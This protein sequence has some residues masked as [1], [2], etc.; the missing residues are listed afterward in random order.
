MHQSLAL[1][2]SGDERTSAAVVDFIVIGAMRA[3]TTMLNDLL[4]QHPE[5]AMARMKETDFFIDTKNYRLGTDWYGSQFAPGARLRGEVSPNYSK[6]RD[7]PDVPRRIHGHCPAVRLVYML[8]DPVE[9]ALS[10]Y[11]HGWSMGR[12]TLLPDQL[13]GG[14]QYEGMVDASRY[15]RQLAQYHRH[16][17]AEQ[18]LILDFESFRADP[19][20][21]Y[22]ALLRHIGAAP[23]PVPSARRQNESSELARVP[24]PLLK[25]A[26]GPLRPVLTRV[27][28]PAVRGQLRRLM[29]R[30]PARTPP[31]FT[32]KLRD[33]LCD[34]LTED[35]ATLRAMTG[36]AFPDWSV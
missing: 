15:A 28:N 27:F 25:L 35:A 36:Q 4:A 31:E 5:I 17:P 7:F 19:Q 10:H 2:A 26:Q 1:C 11:A 33:H 20:P 29:A 13:I 14:P 3:G 32:Q 24:K 21:H 8:R 18:I 30:G 22:D 12:I 16:F 6:A 9:R 23:M 34:D